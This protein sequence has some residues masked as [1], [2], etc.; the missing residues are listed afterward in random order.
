MTIWAELQGATG[1]TLD[2]YLQYQADALADWIDFAHFA[3]LAAG[4]IASDVVV[5][6]QKKTALV[7]A[8]AVGKGTTPALAAGTFLN[9]DWGTAVRVLFVAGAGTTLGKTQ[10]LKLTM[11]P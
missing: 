5:N 8:T 11:S 3:Q 4:A 2:I 1:G 9:I 6:L 10:T 7:A